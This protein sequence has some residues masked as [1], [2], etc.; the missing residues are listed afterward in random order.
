MHEC[1]TLNYFLIV[2]AKA[3][4]T[5]VLDLAARTFFSGAAVYGEGTPDD[6]L[7]D[8][9]TWYLFDTEEGNSEPLKV[10]AKTV[11]GTSPNVV[12]KSPCCCKKFYFP[13]LS[14]RKAPFE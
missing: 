12:E 8:K 10:F 3:P 7:A 6:E 4:V 1:W 2:L 13:L 11:L 9:R 14:C 5:V